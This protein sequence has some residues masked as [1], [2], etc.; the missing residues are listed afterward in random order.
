M[1]HTTDAPKKRPARDPKIVIDEGQLAHIEGLAEGA[2]QRNPAL[3]DRLLGEISRARVVPTAKMPRTVVTI[4]STVT[5]RDETT[6]QEKAVTL[7]FPEHA[8]IAQQRVSLMT[9]IGVTLLGLSEGAVFHWDTRDNERRKLTVIR[10]DQ[11]A[12]SG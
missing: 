9:P 2:M 11:P 12:V 5:Y 10:V 4:G 8:D 1:S 7:V 6:G 3:A